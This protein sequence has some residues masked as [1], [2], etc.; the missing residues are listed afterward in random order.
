MTEGRTGT[1][2]VVSTPIGNMGDFSF[3]A[4]EVLKAVA[5]VL[6]EDTRHSRHLLDRYEITTPLV[7]YHEHN[8]AKT[9]G[10]LVT[11]LG[12]GEDLALISDAGT[13]L[14]SDPG[15]RLVRAAVHA[16]I[17]VSPIPG[18][19]ALLAAL[20]A[21][22]QD[23]DRFTFYG[24]L[25]RKGPARRTTIAEITALRHAAVIYEAPSRLA[26]TLA[27]LTEAGAAER[28]TVIARELTKQYEELRRGTVG[29]LAAY[30][31]DAAPRGEVVIIVAG[32]EAPAS[33]TEAAL[34]ARA[35]DLRAEGQ[36]PRDVVAAL[37]AELGAS[38]NVAY[39]MAHE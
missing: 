36:S 9:T 12:A 24:F 19:S 27:E 37:M 5:V 39:R 35:A 3:R 18:A 1:L 21:S 23:I 4:V 28:A 31:S 7:A 22:G 32:A 13:P 2:Y 34:R 10:G 25:P 26:D 16:G 14:L 11:R 8:E 33:A 20:V 6:A 29:A 17:R 15:A 38:R 30:Y